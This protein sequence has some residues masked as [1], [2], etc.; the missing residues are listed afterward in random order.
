MRI[1]F[2]PAAAFVGILST[3]TTVVVEGWEWSDFVVGGSSSVKPLTI[4]EVSDLRVREIKRRLALHHGYSADELGRMLDKKD[5]IQELAFA[6]EKLRREQETK[7]QRDVAIQGIVAAVGT[8]LVVFLWPL[9]RRAFEV[10]Q[11]NFVVFTDRKA[12][13][14]K[15]CSELRS[16]TA[17]VGVLVMGVLDILQVWLTASVLLSWVMRSKYFFPIPHIPVRPAQMM[18]G[19]IAKSP[20]ANY[21]IN[22][23][24]MAVTWV[25]RFVYDRVERWTGVEMVRAH[26]RQRAEQKARR[27]QERRTARQQ[28]DRASAPPQELPSEWIAHDEDDGEFE[29][30]PSTL[31]ELD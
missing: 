10:A 20:A 1:R 31:E 3:T 13:E 29:C 24:S 7:S 17:L 21:G 9:I 19:D 11:I 25:M 12:H 27:K 26:K 14:W 15:R 16:L 30:E 8:I 4:Y 18:G 5:L 23:G 28:N 6:E 22:V 2:L